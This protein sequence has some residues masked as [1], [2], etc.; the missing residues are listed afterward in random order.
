MRKTCPECKGKID[1]RK[2]EYYCV[3]CGLI[4]EEDGSTG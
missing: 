4:L 2:G 1:S 3:K